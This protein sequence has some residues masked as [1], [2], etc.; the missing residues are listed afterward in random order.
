M[1]GFEVYKM[2]LALKL[3]FTSD[4]YDYFQYGG[5]AKASQVSFDQRRDKF[6]FVKLSRKFKDFEL[7]EFFVANFIEEDKVYPAT[8]VREGAKNYAEYIKRKESL[9]YKFKED[10]ET[11]REEYENFDDLFSVTLVH[12]PLIKAHLGGRICIETL[13]I[14]NKIFQYI[15][16]FDK[17]IKDEIVWKP[18]RNKVVKY[19]PFLQVDKGKYKS[20]IKA[21]YV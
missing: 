19:E 3:H 15:P 11:L 20:I 5:N 10:C 7:R 17:T 14:F 18:L 2:Y 16:Q 4:S 13:T 12:P 1:T 6:F 9:S 8:L 21:Q